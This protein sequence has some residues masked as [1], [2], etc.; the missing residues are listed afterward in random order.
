MV[1]DVE[2]RGDY[3]YDYEDDTLELVKEI[4]DHFDNTW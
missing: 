1:A 4:F 2:N 3:S